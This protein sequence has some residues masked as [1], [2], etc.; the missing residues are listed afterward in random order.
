MHS[1]P[2]THEPVQPSMFHLHGSAGSVVVVV[3]HVHSINPISLHNRSA[4]QVPIQSFE[5]SSHLHG[6]DAIVVLVVVLVEVVVLEVKVVVV[7][8]LQPQNGHP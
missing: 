2:G 5:L 7:V 6:P 4:S 3:R 8:T 1:D